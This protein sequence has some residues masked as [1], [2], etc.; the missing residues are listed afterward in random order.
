MFWWSARAFMVSAL[1]A[2]LAL[3]A[4][5]GGPVPTHETRANLRKLLALPSLVVLCF[6]PSPSRPRLE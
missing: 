6:F 5:H 4:R 3:E 2:S 1:L